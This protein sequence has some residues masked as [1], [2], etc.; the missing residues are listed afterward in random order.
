MLLD[1]TSVML[2]RKD[3]GN[4][5]FSKSVSTFHFHFTKAINTRR[6]KSLL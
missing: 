3:L 6:A 2:G 4:E 1:E 5:G